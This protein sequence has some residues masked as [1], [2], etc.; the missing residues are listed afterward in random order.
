MLD[1]SN[2]TNIV[3]LDC[4][5]N[6]LEQLDVSANLELVTLNCASNDIKHLDLK[7]NVKLSSLDCQHNPSLK[8][9]DVSQNTALG[10]LNCATIGMTNLDISHNTNLTVLK[11]FSN[12]L[13]ILDISNYGKIKTLDCSSN[14][15][16]FETLPHGSFDIY[17]YGNQAPLELQGAVEVGNDIDLSS[18][19]AVANKATSYSWITESGR[20]LQE[21]VD[22]SLNQG[23]TRFL[24]AQNEKVSC[25]MVNEKLP[26]LS[27]TTNLITVKNSILNGSS[28]VLNTEKSEGNTINLSMTADSNT[29]ILVDFGDGNYSNFVVK[30]SK[31]NVAGKVKGAAITVYG[32]NI[33]DFY[34]NGQKVIA[35]NVS[36][37]PSLSALYC[38]DNSL[39]SLNITENTNL[40]T[41]I[42]RN[43]RFDFNSLPDQEILKDN[44][45]Y[46]T[47]S[48]APQATITIA[49]S[50]ELN[51]Q[52]DLA[53]HQS[54]NGVSTVYTWKTSTG[55]ALK[56]GA[57][58]VINA[59]V[60]TFLKPQSDKV[61]CE[62]TNAKFP[63]LTLK[64]SEVSLP[65]PTGIGNLEADNIRLYTKHRTVHV[66]S[67]NPGQ[68]QVYNLSGHKV[69]T[70]VL[71]AGHDT[72]ELKENGI[73][74]IRLI[75][76]SKV[77]TQK[78]S[79]R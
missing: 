9:L 39:T 66:A 49:E 33:K 44:F 37:M 52:L 51:E 79:I 2:N 28:I 74:I 48:Y 22:Y 31:T 64:S 46:Y 17:N 77:Y 55:T 57:D 58:Y 26:K 19:K 6:N 7:H 11:C 62:M 38:Y 20:Y 71:N 4:S 30:N 59:G 42:C 65:K 27:M 68:Y 24:K 78:I 36:N 50:I 73:Y 63:E 41:L 69:K 72:F 8:T 32:S 21:G 45:Q 70:G 61:Y 25:L 40:R 15:L 60:T 75:I 3:E 54:S 13:S 29:E 56:E 18:Q 23:I 47:Y 34:C 1:L 76:N 67:E 5:Q 14:R 12:Q 35:L 10:T 53:E 43:N 16:S